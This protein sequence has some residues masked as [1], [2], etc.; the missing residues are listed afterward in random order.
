MLDTNEV[1]KYNGAVYK[2]LFKNPKVH[3]NT[4]KKELVQK[5]KFPSKDKCSKVIE[6]LIAL[7]KI[8]VDKENVSLNPDLLNLGVLQ[9]K[10]N[11][12]YLVTPN[13]NKTYA[14]SNSV[15]AGY[16]VGDILEIVIEHNGKQSD[17]VIL[18][19][20][21]REIK[22]TADKPKEVQAQK[23]Y[24]N[25]RNRI[26]ENLF[27]DTEK[28]GLKPNE[29]LGRVVKLSHDELVFIPNKKSIPIRQ[30]P[31]LNNKEEM[32]KYEDK[33]CVMSMVD[34][35]T[36]YSGGYLTDIKGD[37]GNMLEE[38]Q[39]IADSYGAVMNWLD[40][41]VRKEI[42]LIPKT[43][44]V[45]ALNLIT[46]SQARYMQKGNTVDLRH[47]PFVTVDPATCKDMDDAIYSTFD[48]NGDF[49]CYTAVANVTKYVSPD[50]EIFK[51][52]I[53]AVFTLYTPNKAYSVL[54]PELSTQICSL[55]PNEDR[56]ALV[57]KTVID[58]NTGKVKSSNIYD[59]VIRSRA[60]YSY[61]Q[62]QEIVDTLDNEDARRVLLYKSLIGEKLSLEE[63]TLMNY[64]TAQAIKYGFDQR[65]MIRFTSSKERE[66]V[67]DS[68]LKD[69]VDI[70]TIPHLLYHEVIE[71]FMVTAN[72]V[73]AKYARDKGINT[74]YR[75]HDEPNKRKIQRADEFF[76]ILGID[77]DGNL[78]AQGTRNLIE[79]IRNTA[80]EEV[81][82]NFLIKMQSRAVYSDKLHGGNSEDYA[83]E[84]IGE[85]ISHYALQ[86]LHYSHS[87]SPIR[88]AP[89]FI[90]HYN[91]LADLHEKEPLSK[92]VIFEIIENANERQIEIDQAEKDLQDVSSA[93]YCEKHIGETMH[94]RVSKIR[95]TS[96]EEGYEDEI[97]V[98]VK[99]DEKGIS[100]EIPLS[101]VLGRP[102]K[103]CILSAQRCA[104][105]DNKG[106]ILLTLCKPVDFIIEKADRK[107]MNIV[108]RTNKELVK[109]AEERNGEQNYRRQTVSSGLN[110]KQAKQKRYKRYEQNKVHHKKHNQDENDGYQKH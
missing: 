4:L 23:K 43:V 92:D 10:G 94:G 85:Q 65:R 103:N 29:L 83:S 109:A 93:I 82:N 14:V 74:I 54:P 91:I 46:E 98:I 22:R 20:S 16:T 64:Y 48:E 70:K 59:S 21:Q 25:Q 55:N 68:D 47:I 100:A 39:S 19:K 78:S 101:Q 104:V 44:D 79:L 45:D 110:H 18:G 6:S 102:S 69:I 71:A 61:E 62:A 32:A 56:L 66:I 12:F 88:R 77:F 107:T 51:R 89:D 80:I 31:I 97:V 49:V 52:Y 17:A 41:E 53:R 36:P 106:N 75:V 90:V 76:N 28:L 57:M 86:S 105:Y 67:F 96:P 13:S 24:G 8:V 63:Q 34:I 3:K 15:A 1:L 84:W 99:N 5:G 30:I 9:K 58:K 7:G 81:I 38:Y 35:N 37:A 26:R 72:E 60:K 33:L 108:G 87:T 95:Y 27:G 73:T 11:N 2:Y 40:P 50:S 42:E